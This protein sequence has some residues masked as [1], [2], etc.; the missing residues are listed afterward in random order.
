MYIFS[1]SHVEK[2]DESMHYSDFSVS[3]MN[4][5][6]DNAEAVDLFVDVD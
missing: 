5:Q 3:I 2:Q 6:L 1:K 4:N